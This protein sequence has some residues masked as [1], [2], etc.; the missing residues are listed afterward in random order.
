MDA[1]RVDALPAHRVRARNLAPDSD[2]KIHDDTVAR[3]FGFTG[4]LVPGV[5]VFA[6]ATHPFVHAWGEEFLRRG[7]IHA[8]FRRPVYDGEEVDVTAEPGADGRYELNVTGPD[9]VVRATGSGRLTDDPPAVDVTSIAD[10]PAPAERPTADAVSLA[11]GT[12][13]AT[14]AEPVDPE[15]HALYRKGVGDDLSLYERFAHPGVLLRMVNAVLYRNVA[16]GPWIH[17]ESACRLL[18]PAPVPSRLQARG[19]VTD[20][21]ERDGRS[22][23]RFDAVVLADDRPVMYAD[24]RA[25]YDLGSP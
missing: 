4:A 12:V 13:L 11:V 19:V 24:H 20:R 5:E 8:R 25:I 6:Y 1:P 7:E 9:G 15:P 17:T 2:N 10:V 21:Y 14:V 23:V 18:A 3:Q 22:W 16:M